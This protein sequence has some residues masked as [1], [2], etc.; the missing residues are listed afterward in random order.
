MMSHRPFR[1]DIKAGTFLNRRLLNSP[2][3]YKK[4]EAYYIGDPI[5]F[6]FAYFDNMPMGSH[7]WCAEI[8]LASGEGFTFSR[9]VFAETL[10]IFF[11][12]KYY[13]NNIRLQALIS[14]E[15]RQALRLAQLAGF[16][17][18]GRLRNVATDGDRIL[19]SLLKEEFEG[20]YGR[21]FQQTQSSNTT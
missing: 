14:P 6:A 11:R 2:T 15:N 19:L 13:S 9:R 3:D 1:D 7:G 20:R 17:I 21:Y 10:A 5:K 18:E 8:A 12:N 16:Q 4:A